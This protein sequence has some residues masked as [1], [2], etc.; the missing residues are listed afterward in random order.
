ME[1][2]YGSSLSQTTL[3]DTLRQTNRK[4]WIYALP[5]FT[6]VKA[7]NACRQMEEQVFGLQLHDRWH[8]SWRKAQRK[9]N[10]LVCLSGGLLAS[11]C[12][13]TLT[14]T[15]TRVM[16]KVGIGSLLARSPCLSL[17]E[18]I[19]GTCVYVHESDRLTGRQQEPV[20]CRQ[21]Q[22]TS[23]RRTGPNMPSFMSNPSPSTNW[24]LSSDL[25]LKHHNKRMP[26]TTFLNVILF[27]FLS[28]FCPT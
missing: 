26:E 7:I 12:P 20:T 10:V 14:D 16:N 24:F 28:L 27:H 15:H 9:Y 19:N 18:L 11:Y 8:D 4:F 17:N 2:K 1:H 23:I 5:L 22:D 25:S 6:A 21:S 3:C 13:Q